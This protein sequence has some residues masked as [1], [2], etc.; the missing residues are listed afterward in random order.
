MKKKRKRLNRKCI[1]SDILEAVD[2]LKTIAEKLQKD[3][4]FEEIGFQTQLNHAYHHLN[5]AWNSRFSTK[6]EYVDLTDARFNK[7][8]K[9]PAKDFK[10]YK[11]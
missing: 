7:W 2:E 4:R 9:Y 1:R 5:Y 10:D 8:S 6:K 3:P 11:V